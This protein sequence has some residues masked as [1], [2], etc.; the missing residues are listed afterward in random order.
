MYMSLYKGACIYDD[1]FIIMHVYMMIYPFEH[2]QGRESPFKAVI[3]SKMCKKLSIRIWD[4]NLYLF[5]A[6]G[7]LT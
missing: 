7:M 2:P 4:K 1:I 3:F 5:R 6:A